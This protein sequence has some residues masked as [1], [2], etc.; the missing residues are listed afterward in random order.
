MY[1]LPC[2]A[3]DLTAAQITAGV[4]RMT[5]QQLRWQLSP[6]SANRARHKVNIQQSIGQHWSCRRKYTLIELLNHFEST[7]LK[8][9]C[10]S[11]GQWVL[12]VDNPQDVDECIAR[13]SRTF[14]RADED[15]GR[16]LAASQ[17]GY[18]FGSLAVAAATFAVWLLP[19]IKV[20]TYDNISISRTDRLGNNS[21]ARHCAETY[22]PQMIPSG[23]CPCCLCS[24][25]KHCSC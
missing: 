1:F 16:C 24:S 2:T 23:P 4:A 14:G 5:T 12:E 17:R 8:W 9:P 3:Q 7:L 20:S 13:I 15:I 21:N 19:D 11:R 10:A 25:L 18:V 6:P 22:N